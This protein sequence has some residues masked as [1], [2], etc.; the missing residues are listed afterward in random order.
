MS[1]VKNYF[2]K[3]DSL[4]KKNNCLFNGYPINTFILSSR[5]RQSICNMNVIN[6][7]PLKNTLLSNR[8]DYYMNIHMHSL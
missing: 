7:E 3:F 1:F 6:I 5:R 2:T 4:N 8:I